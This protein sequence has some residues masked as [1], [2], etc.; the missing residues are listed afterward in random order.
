M[1]ISKRLKAVAAMVSDDMVVADIGTDHGYI[2]IYLVKEKN[3]K[4]AYAMDINEGPLLRA[5]ENIQKYQVANLVETRLSD[6]LHALNVGEAQSIVIAGMGGLLIN[7]ILSEGVDVINS[8]EELI[9]SPHSD[10]AQVR[11]FLK[12]NGFKIIDEDI[13]YDEE[14]Y[15]FILK[16]IPGSMTFDDELDLQ[17]GR[18]LFDKKK[19]EFRDYLCKELDK[20]ETILN[21]MNNSSNKDRKEELNKEIDL[22]KRG[23]A[24]YEG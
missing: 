19:T 8:A 2:P 17:Y 16:A 1:N 12:K 22:I 23:L 13:V 11:Y 4:K 15:Y 7:K 6:G 10:I 18:N 9:L 21:K 3:H 14:K 20:R 24:K 5:K